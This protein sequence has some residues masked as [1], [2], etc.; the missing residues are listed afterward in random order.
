MTAVIALHAAPA[1]SR[2]GGALITWAVPIFFL[3]AGYLWTP[4]RTVGHELRH[5]AESLLVP[6][7]AWTAIWL[8]LNQVA[9][10]L[11]GIP[12]DDNA[13][14]NF[15]LGGADEHGAFG[16]YWFVP[17]FFVATVG[18]RALE[19]AGVSLAG[20]AAIGA[21]GLAA[22]SVWGDVL[23]H[24]PHDAFFA[25]PLMLFMVLGQWLR[26]HEPSRRVMLVAG[27]AMVVVPSV[28]LALRWIEPMD[29]KYGEFGQVGL[30]FGAGLLASV[31]VLWFVKSVVP[32]DVPLV[33]SRI[34]TSMARAI[35]AVLL[36][37]LFIL[38]IVYVGVFGES[39]RFASFVIAWVVSFALGTWIS[40][41]RASRLLVG[42]P[43]QPNQAVRLVPH[44]A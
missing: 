36:T 5:R 24:V 43:R 13:W 26:A 33:V 42:M 29:I 28:G 23:V 39:Q 37:H 10:G 21:L 9:K 34:V 17:V 30:T 20:R 27:L 4:G 35:L 44:L 41:T 1:G 11:A 40:R 25:L 2:L 18:Y 12:L 22:S 32:D 6:M 38:G 15:V 3:L 7:L 14:S 31:G 16:P 19:A 8:M